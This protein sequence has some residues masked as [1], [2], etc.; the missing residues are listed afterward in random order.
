MGESC[1]GLTGP[2]GSFSDEYK[3]FLRKYWEAQA[4][5]FERCGAGWVQWTWKA[6]N[7]DEW[8]YQAGLAHGWIPRD[9]A[10]RKYPDICG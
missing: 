3:A 1:A 8:S 9:P 7:A 6:E 2:A 10:E 4:S 5:T